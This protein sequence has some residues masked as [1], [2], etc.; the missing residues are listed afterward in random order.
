MT[1]PL[2]TWVPRLRDEWGIQP[3]P[4]TFEHA[5]AVRSLPPHHNDPFDRMLVAQAQ[6]ENLTL[7]TVDPAI[8]AYNVRTIDAAR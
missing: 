8:T 6:C 5:I 2:E 7:V 1:D 4:I 3:L